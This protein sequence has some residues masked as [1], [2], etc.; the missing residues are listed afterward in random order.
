MT[1]FMLVAVIY[2]SLHAVS[3]STK[4]IWICF[5]PKIFKF[6]E[7]FRC[8]SSALNG[9]ELVRDGGV[10]LLAML[11]ARCMYVVQRGTAPTDPAAV[12]VTNIMRTFAGIGS[13]SPMEVQ[14]IVTTCRLLV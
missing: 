6:P 9:E 1:W 5:V 14:L 12:I 3:C 8:V 10:S 2:I 4:S 7:S 13:T 11:L